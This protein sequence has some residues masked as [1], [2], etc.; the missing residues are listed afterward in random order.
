MSRIVLAIA[1]LG[2]TAYA[3]KKIQGMTPG[4]VKEAASCQIEVR[5]LARVIAGS[6]E[7]AATLSGAE[8]TQ[9]DADLVAVR[10]ANTNVVAYCTAVEDLAKFLQDNAAA[11]YKSVEK[12]IDTRDNTVRKLRKDAKKALADITPVTRS[13]IPRI[14]RTPAPD[15]NVIE[16]E[17]VAF[18]SKRKV[19]LPSMSGGSWAV[20]GSSTSDVATF[21]DKLGSAQITTRPFENAACEQQRKAFGERSDSPAA[22]LEV[23]PE[24][25]KL[26]VAWSGRL[27]TRKPVVTLLAMCAERKMGGVM[28]TAALT[29]ATRKTLDAD[30]TKVMIAMLAAQL[31]VPK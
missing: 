21:T 17:A 3:D 6:A 20:S 27:Q 4:F 23:T 1:V 26:G 19:A 30:V 29:P 2:A 25:E 10:A 31:E 5:G 15:T 12:D 8:R 16:V 7:L 14:K 24:A 18:P 13:L 9:L 22:A 11:T 28:V